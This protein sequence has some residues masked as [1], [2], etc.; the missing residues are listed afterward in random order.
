MD[1]GIIVQQVLLALYLNMKP[2]CCDS[3]VFDGG[4]IDLLAAGAEILT[5]EFF[6]QAQYL[7]LWY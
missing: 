3:S 1:A 2:N 6:Q 5:S 4:E 7:S